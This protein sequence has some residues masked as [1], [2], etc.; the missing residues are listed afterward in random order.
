MRVHLVHDELEVAG[1]ELEVGVDLADEVEVVFV[2]GLIT[3]VEGGD[4]ARADTALAG[5]L[6]VVDLEPR[7]LGLGFGEDAWCVVGGSVVDEEAERR[8]LGLRGEGVD[9]GLRVLGFV[10]ARADERVPP[11]LRGR[12]VVLGRL[13]HRLRFPSRSLAVSS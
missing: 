8:R 12:G 10:L 4:D 7:V 6:A 1:R 13:G 11:T 3:L 9:G 2:D 5:V